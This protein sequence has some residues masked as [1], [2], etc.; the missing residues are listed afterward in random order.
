[1]GVTSPLPS[2]TWKNGVPVPISARE[3]PGRFGLMKI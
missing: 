1:M 3:S 2:C